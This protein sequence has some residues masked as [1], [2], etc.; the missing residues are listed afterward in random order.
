MK[1]RTSKNKKP[2]LIGI[3]VVFVAAIIAGLAFFFI[4]KNPKA[5]ADT[6]D[7]S[8]AFSLDASKTTGWWAADNNWPSAEPKSQD[9]T[10][11]QMTVAQGTKE[12]PGTC[13]VMYFYKPGTVDAE[14]EANRYKEGASTDTVTVQ[15]KESKQF[16]MQTSDGAKEFKLHQYQLVGSG[17]G[18]LASGV[19]LGY[20][21]LSD[22]YV[23][24]RGHCE[25]YEQ[26]SGASTVFEAVSLK[27]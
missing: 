22:G 27:Q 2:V 14:A 17:A 11:V 21:P 24:I 16:T 3:G 10:I 23:E 18:Q 12:Q 15:E 9:A 7:K 1:I 5:D 20:V 19:Q 13:F 25:S 8:S 26:L 4:N 6:A